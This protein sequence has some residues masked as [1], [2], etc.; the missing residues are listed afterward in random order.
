MDSLIKEAT[1]NVIDKIWLEEISRIIYDIVILKQFPLSMI[2]ES[3]Q[4][5]QGLATLVFWAFFD[6]KNALNDL[7]TL[8]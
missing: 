5:K 7:A 3:L 8:Y 6:K 2:N 4:E 1:I